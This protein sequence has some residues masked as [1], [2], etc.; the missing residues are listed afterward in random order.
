MFER[1]MIHGA[2]LAL[3]AARSRRSSLA[4]ELRG[5]V[6]EG[7]EVG[8]ESEAVTLEGVGLRRRSALDPE[9]RWLLAGRRR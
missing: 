4:E 7:I 1:L 6:P 2:A 8:V 9:L 5:E 3:K